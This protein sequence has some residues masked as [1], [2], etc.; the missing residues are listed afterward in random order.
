MKYYD[1]YD[2]EEAYKK[3]CNNLEE[4]EIEKL[5]KEGRISC[6][7]RTTTT[8]SKNIHSG[9]VF[10]ETQIYPT[11]K[12]PKEVPKTKKKRE[13]KPSQRN[14]NDINA[15]RHLVRLLNINFTDGDIWAT[16]GWNDDQMPKTEEEAKRQ[17]SNFVKRINYR[18]KK[19]GEENIRYIY[20]LAFDGYVRPH[21]HIVM[22]GQ[23][24]DRDELEQLWG[25]CD[26]PNTR[27]IK[28]DKDFM[29]CGMAT[30][31]GR[32]PHGKK[33]WC[34]SKNLKKP[35]KPTR[36]Y[37]KFTKRKVEKMVK[38]HDKIKSQMEQAYPGYRFLDAE[39]KYNGINAAFYIYARMTRD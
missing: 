33:R 1:N 11:F 20:V 8:K 30:Y 15:R 18:R 12:T 34:P 36:S 2:Y 4:W 6:L 24:I 28:S 5:M 38:D 32:N 17:I 39:V 31:M 7:Y 10:L 37:K 35:D 13:T 25:K 23:G 21:F 29:L 22:T 16:F 26:R 27:R 9:K 3:Q 14:L 19:K